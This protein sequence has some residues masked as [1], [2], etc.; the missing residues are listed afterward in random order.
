MKQGFV[1]QVFSQVLN[2]LSDMYI[3]MKKNSSNQQAFLFI[4][5]QIY[6]TTT[7]IYLEAY[8]V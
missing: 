4:Q 5:L 1:R 6:L 7:Q 8:N 2:K 3:L